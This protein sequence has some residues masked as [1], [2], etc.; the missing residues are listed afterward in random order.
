MPLARPFL[1]SPGCKN[2][3]TPKK[4][5]WCRQAFNNT[6]NCRPYPMQRPAKICEKMKGTSKKTKDPMGKFEG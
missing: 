5:H 2:S 6:F 4:K 1:D 3:P